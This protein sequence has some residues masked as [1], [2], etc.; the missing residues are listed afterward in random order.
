MAVNPIQLQKYLREVDYPARKEDL[1]R[2]AEQHGAD[3]NVLTTLRAIP[4]REYNGPNAVSEAVGA[5]T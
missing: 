3:E 1:I 4:E 2:H 5:E